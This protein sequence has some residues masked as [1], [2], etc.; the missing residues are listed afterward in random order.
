M[1]QL[2][3]KLEES[4]ASNIIKPPFLWNGWNKLHQPKIQRVH[5]QHVNFSSVPQIW[6][7]TQNWT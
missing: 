1:A 3:T 6:I 2:I 7:L 5:L 4:Y